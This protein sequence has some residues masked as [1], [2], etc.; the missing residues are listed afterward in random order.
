MKRMDRLSPEKQEKRRAHNRENLALFFGGKDKHGQARSKALEAL[1]PKLILEFAR[2][3]LDNQT[4]IEHIQAYAR[5]F[6]QAVDEIDETDIAYATDL[7]R[8][9]N[10]LEA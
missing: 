3:Y 10:V 4:A 8:V 9:Q 2:M 7:L 1:G 6:K 5:R